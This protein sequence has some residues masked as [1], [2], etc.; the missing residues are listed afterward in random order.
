MIHYVLLTR[1]DLGRSV[2]DSRVIDV[3]PTDGL[4]SAGRVNAGIDVMLSAA[5]ETGTRETGAR[6]TGSDRASSAA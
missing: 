5:R 6:E 1:D 3:D 4:D 2:V